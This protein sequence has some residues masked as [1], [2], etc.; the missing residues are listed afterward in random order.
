MI[1]CSHT[2]VSTVLQGSSLLMQRQLHQDDPPQCSR[3][4]GDLGAPYS[5]ADLSGAISNGTKIHG[6]GALYADKKTTRRTKVKK[7]TEKCIFQ[8]TSV[9]GGWENVF[10]DVNVKDLDSKRKGGIK[11]IE[12]RLVS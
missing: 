7:G 5:C 6:I 11:G 1:M 4:D 10:E 9:F 8:W 12:G 3:Q 2:S